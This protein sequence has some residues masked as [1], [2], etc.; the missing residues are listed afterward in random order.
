MPE[1]S[2]PARTPAALK[3]IVPDKLRLGDEIRVLA[4]SRSLGG[5]KQHPG[6]TEADIEFARRRL[7]SLGLRVTFG[8]H[9]MEANAHL[10]IPVRA[11]LEDLYDALD[12]DAVKGILAASG[13]MGAIQL[14][15]QLDCR[16][17]AAHPKILCGYS[18]IGFLCNAIY[19]RTGLVTYYG[20]HFSTF[21]MRNGG[22]YTWR[23][24]Q[25]CLFGS[26]PFEAIPSQEWS[27]D[28]W[29]ADQE[30]R[31]YMPNEGWW[32]IN[33]GEAEGTV[34]GGSFYCLNLLQG[35]EFFPP[36]KGA[37]LFLEHPSEGKGSLMNLDGG[38]RALSFQPQFK[39]IRG[40]VIGRFAGNAGI[41]RGKMA[42]MIKDIPELARV[43]VVANCDFGHTSPMLTLPIGSKCRIKVT[44]D[45]TEITIFEH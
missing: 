10:T 8:R 7:E 16:R 37:I 5:L 28:N 9:V 4:L 29:W 23:Y 15:K 39:H 26:R 6:I 11:R 44:T 32:G 36:L 33:D 31:N 42:A 25:A 1:A 13:G 21:T 40:I 19:A 43:P 45:K 17:F 12:N 24:F 3:R 2:S 27:D 14:L 22:D 20:P 38:I 30:H 18:D 34:I 35:G 41:D